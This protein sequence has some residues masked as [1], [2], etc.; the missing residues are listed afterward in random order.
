[1]VDAC[2]LVTGKGWV[3]RFRIFQRLGR[4][5]FCSVSTKI[6]TP[7]FVLTQNQKHRLLSLYLRPAGRRVP[8]SYQSYQKITR[9]VFSFLFS[10]G[11]VRGWGCCCVPD[12]VRTM[13]SPLSHGRALDIKI[14]PIAPIGPPFFPLVY[15]SVLVGWW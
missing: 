6:S 7:F 3:R 14:A 9:E 11:W 10:F 15:I 1:M 8:P 12:R 4:I 2:K 13:R 5:Q